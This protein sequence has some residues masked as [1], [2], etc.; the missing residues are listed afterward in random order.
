MLPADRF[1]AVW[2]ASRDWFGVPPIS[3]LISMKKAADRHQ[4]RADVRRLE[5]RQKTSK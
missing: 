4:D 1:V 2:E 3:D 5:R